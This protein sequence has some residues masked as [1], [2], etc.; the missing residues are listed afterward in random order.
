[1]VKNGANNGR[2]GHEKIAVHFQNCSLCAS[3]I[4]LTKKLEIVVCYDC[5]SNFWGKRRSVTTP[6]MLT[7]TRQMEVD[8][9]Q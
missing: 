5:Y 7:A 8:F 3:P 4:A 1:M 6:G 2:L 9:V